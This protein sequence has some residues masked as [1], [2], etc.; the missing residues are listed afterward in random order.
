MSETLSPHYASSRD[1]PA[2][3]GSAGDGLARGIAAAAEALLAQQRADGHWA[4]ELEA[5]A[6]IPT[7]Y[8]LLQ[9]YLDEIDEEVQ[10][11]LAH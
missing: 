5:D 8:I 10:R 7:E 3:D 6:T 2:D 9:H 11:A 1:R 4:F